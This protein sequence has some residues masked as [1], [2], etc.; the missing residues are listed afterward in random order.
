MCSACMCKMGN[1]YLPKTIFDKDTMKCIYA[2]YKQM[3]KIG[4][5]TFYYCKTSLLIGLS[6]SFDAGELVESIPKLS[7]LN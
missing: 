6:L 1:I 7:C 4:S 2:T 5:Y 3:L